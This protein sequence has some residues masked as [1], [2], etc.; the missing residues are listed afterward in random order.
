MSTK[1]YYFN[2]TVKW[3]K[4]RKPD[5][6]YNDY[7]INLYPTEASLAEI[8]TSGVQVQ[9]KEDEDGVYYTFR[10]KH[11]ALEK[12]KVKVY[13]PPQV[14]DADNTVFEGLIGNG[15]KVTA[16]VEVYD[17]QKGKGHR[18]MIVRVDDLVEYNPDGV[19]DVGMPPP[20]A[21]ASQKKPSTIK[22]PF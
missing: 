10:R 19:T 11:E 9:P 15:S 8:K 6:K 12:G 4:V 21:Q 7:K 3:A 16:K 1:N 2:G 13:G 20:I 5:E 17:T 14:L 18:L 22:P